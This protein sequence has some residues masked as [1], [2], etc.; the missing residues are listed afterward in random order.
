MFYITIV[1]FCIDLYK[2]VWSQREDCAPVAWVPTSFRAEVHSPV[3]HVAWHPHR[4]SKAW[5]GS[6]GH[7]WAVLGSSLLLP[8]HK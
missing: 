7:I 8:G 2:H 4:S 6:L 5:F 1:V 3:A